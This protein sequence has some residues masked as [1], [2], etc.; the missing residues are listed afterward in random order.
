MRR[1]QYL[2]LVDQ[3][4]LTLIYLFVILARLFLLPLTVLFLSEIEA[5]L[6]SFFFV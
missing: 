4:T 2:Q 5:I 6:P 3:Y 1:K